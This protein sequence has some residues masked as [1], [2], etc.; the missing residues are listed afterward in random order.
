MNAA[1]VTILRRVNNRGYNASDIN[2]T[3]LGV[4]DLYQSVPNGLQM[5]EGKFSIGGG[6]NSVAHFNDNTGAIDDDVTWVRGKHQ[7][8]FGG[9]W[10]Q[11]ELNIGNVYE[12]NGIFTFNGEYSGSGPKGGSTIGDQNLDFLMGTLS[13]LPAEQEAAERAA[14]AA[15]P[16]STSRTPTT[17]PRVLRW[18]AA[19]AG[20]R[21]SCRTIISIAAWCSTWP[22]SSPTP[23]APSIPMLRPGVFVLRRQGR[24]PRVHQE[25]VPGSSRPTLASSFDPFGNGKTV[26]RAGGALM[27]DNP[28]FFTGQRN[29]QNPP[30]ATAIT[31][32]KRR[33]GTRSVRRSVVGRA[34]SQPT[35]FPQPAVPTPS[36]AL[37]FA[38]SQ[39]IVMP[40]NSSAAYTIQWTLSIQHEFRH[41]WQAQVDYIGNDAARS[42][43][44]RHLTRL[45]SSPATG[46][47]AERAARHRDHRPGE[48]QARRGGN[49][50]LHHQ[51]PDFAIP[52]HHR[53]PTQGNQYRGRRRRLGYRERRSENANYNG[54]VASLQHRLSTISA[55]WPTG[56]GRSASTSRTPRVTMA[57]TT[58]RGN[59]TTV[60]LDYG[61]L[62]LGLPPHRE[63]N[64]LVAR[65]NFNGFNSCR[66]GVDQR[67]G[68][69]PLIHIQSGAPFNVT[70]GADD[71]LT[72]VGNDRP[73]RV[74]GVNP[75]PNA[76]SATDRASRT[77]E[78]LN[79]AAF[80]QICPC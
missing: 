4:D 40:S 21:T 75:M 46:E 53:E 30:F 10:V 76:S 22:I 27:Y 23:S 3:T 28:N 26:I 61:P 41:G 2:A 77:R 55:C 7:I 48:G 73:N 25:L 70:A 43:G 33:V 37:F 17:P 50:L 34:L 1:H 47:R 39:Y 5:A 45:S 64:S 56:P 66:P 16:A 49:Q 31:T 6:T 52:A 72:D 29:Q 69:G 35:R 51:E 8:S 80:A 79:P 65:S 20:G 59:P 18:S 15:F 67:L 14:R 62:R 12:G 58:R 9:E 71:S 63:R 60:A 36:Q 38:Q 54:M 57:G 19:C 68:A 32:R 11:N 74:A 13:R 24:D 42:D 78:Y 44:R